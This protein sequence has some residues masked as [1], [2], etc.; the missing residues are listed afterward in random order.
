MMNYDNNIST[1]SSHLRKWIP[2]EEFL[3]NENRT[4]HRQSLMTENK[5][6]DNWKTTYDQNTSDCQGTK[7][8]LTNNYSGNKLSI[9]SP[10]L[11]EKKSI[12]TYTPSS[13]GRQ[14]TGNMLKL[15][16]GEESRFAPEPSFSIRHQQHDVMAG[17][18]GFGRGFD[19]GVGLGLG[20]ELGRGFG[21]R[22]SL[23]SNVL[24]SSLLSSAAS[25]AVPAF[26]APAFAAPAYSYAA[27]VSYAAPAYS[28][29]A[30][31]PSYAAPAYSYAAPAQTYSYAAPAPSYAAPTYSY[32]APAPSYV[33]P[34]SYAPA[35]VSYSVPQ[36]SFS[37]APPAPPTQVY[38]S[39]APQPIVMQAA[40]QI[41]QEPD[42]I[43][44]QAPAI[45]LP[46]H[47][48][49]VAPQTSSQFAVSGEIAN[50]NGNSFSSAIP[51][52]MSYSSSRPMNFSSN[53][54]GNN[55]PNN[56]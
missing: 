47:T 38:S 51:Q 1:Y 25:F 20:S 4:P 42:T 24:A 15:R 23:A 36:Q 44:E 3:E 33:A 39:P 45:H 53:N 49:E 52:S 50:N 27:P 21:L 46:G 35:P 54:N 26:A 13:S 19:R 10:S 7:V 31:A 28:Y 48:F 8:T 11:T 34:V 40:P 14:D 22:S 37:Y 9:C 30:P 43:I 16:P 32:A 55:H 2:C 29:A 18:G 5:M 56:C 17:C 6:D 12:I 41:I